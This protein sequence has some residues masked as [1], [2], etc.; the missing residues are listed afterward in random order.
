VKKIHENV[1]KG[2]EEGD[3]VRKGPRTFMCVDRES[4]RAHALGQR[5]SA[6]TKERKRERDR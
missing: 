1:K 5:E 3:R 6:R 2:D 4:A